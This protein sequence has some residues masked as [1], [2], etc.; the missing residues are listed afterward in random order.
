MKAPLWVET[1]FDFECCPL[2]KTS[3]IKKAHPG[4]K[5]PLDVKISLLP[6]S[7]EGESSFW[8]Q[9]LVLGCWFF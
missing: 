9:K 3:Y 8:V 1:R 4:V 6:F 7:F 5:T 2:G